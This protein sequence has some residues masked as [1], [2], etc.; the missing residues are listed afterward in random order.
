MLT[1][2]VLYQVKYTAFMH[3][4]TLQGVHVHRGTHH[5]LATQRCMPQSPCTPRVFCE[6]KGS[7]LEN[8]S[9]KLPGQSSFVGDMITIRDVNDT[10]ICLCTVRTTRQ[11]ITHEHPQTKHVCVCVC[12]WCELSRHT[13]GSRYY[14]FVFTSGS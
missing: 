6:R 7:S 11:G 2:T 9:C 14:S 12:V 4:G 13:C 1:A 3:T 5:T 10:S 8:V